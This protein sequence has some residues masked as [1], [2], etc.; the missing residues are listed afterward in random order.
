MP[1]ALNIIQDKISPFTIHARDE[2]VGVH[3][4]QSLGGIENL[5][6]ASPVFSPGISTSY[7]PK[8]SKHMTATFDEL[9]MKELKGESL[10]PSFSDAIPLPQHGPSFVVGTLNSI[11]SILLSI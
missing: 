1:P 9:R 8:A 3:G 2:S 7:L 5:C 11:F 10:R 6:V 4:M